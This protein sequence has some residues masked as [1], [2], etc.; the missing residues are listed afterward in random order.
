M[1]IINNWHILSLSADWGDFFVV[2]QKQTFLA[3]NTTTNRQTFILQNQLAVPCLR[4]DD[5]YMY[6]CLPH[7]AV[8]V[9]HI[10]SSLS[11]TTL[12]QTP[13]VTLKM[14]HWY[15]Q[16]KGWLITSMHP[17]ACKYTTKPGNQRFIICQ[18]SCTDWRSVVSSHSD[19][20]ISH[21]SKD[22]KLSNPQK[23]RSLKIT[24]GEKH[25]EWKH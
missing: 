9:F 21:L 8:I 12:L 25:L 19:Q 4:D 2:Q 3:K 24:A 6:R 11:A 14:L 7:T 13:N 16:G 5:D 22:L 23:L 20:K 1:P 15:K 10:C 18:G 17:L